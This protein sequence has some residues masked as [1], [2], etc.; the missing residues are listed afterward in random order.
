M[1]HMMELPDNVDSPPLRFQALEN[2]RLIWPLLFL[3]AHTQTATE[4]IARGIKEL[5]SPSN[6]S[7]LAF[8]SLECEAGDAALN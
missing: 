1:L 4:K 7:C 5:I 8:Y 3:S 2:S 6:R